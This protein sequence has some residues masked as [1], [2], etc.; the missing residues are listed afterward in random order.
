MSNSMNNRQRIG[1]N[2]RVINLFMPP[3]AAA[4]LIVAAF[5]LLFPA[6]DAAAQSAAIQGIIS[7]RSDGQPLDGA[8]IVLQEVGDPDSFR[9]TVTDRNGFYQMSG[10]TPGRHSVRISYIGYTAYEDTLSLEAD[11]R[12]T[13]TVSLA[14][15]DEELG[16]VVVSSQRH[17]A[18][19]R[20][21][22]HQRVSSVDLARVPTPAGG[23][24]LASYLQAMPGV[25]A[26]GD[27]GGQ[28]FIRGGTPSQNMVLVDGSVIY[29]PFHIVG[30]FSAFPEELV[31]TADFYAG[32][33]G[34]RY[35]SRISSVLDVQMRDGDRYDTGGSG[36][37]SP[38]VAEIHAEGP[39]REGSSSWIASTRHSLLE[40]T[41][42]ALLG[43]RQPLHFESQYLRFSHTAG[44]NS[45]CSVMALRTYD[46]GRLDFESDDVF[47]WNN[48]VL[49]GRCLALPEGSPLFLETNMGV[50]HMSNAAGNMENPELFSSATRFN[51]DVNLTQNLGDVRL[52]YG[53]FALMKWFNYEMREL[54]HEP[55]EASDV[56]L[57]SGVHFEASIP[58]GDRV[59]IR[60]GAVL[61]IYV[62]TYSPSVEPRIRATWQP[63]GREEEELSASIG[64]Y[65]QALVGVSDMRDASS[66]FVAWM[67]API[68]GSQMEAIH[69]LLGWR[70]SLGGGFQL[71]LEGYHKRLRNLPVT[72]WSTIA[73]FSTDLAL[74]DGEVYGG[75]IRLEL[76]RGPFYGFAGYGYTWT[77]YE[78]A[79]DHFNT[80]FGEPVQK[81]H[82]PHD[83]RH[84]INA[85]AS[86]DVG[87][88]TTSA[89]WQLGSGLP[90]TRP[91]G[92]DEIIFF[93]EQLPNVRREYGTPRVILEKPYQGRLPVYHRLDVSVETSIDF[94][95]A[96]LMAQAGA[97]NTY[98]QNNLF[99]YDVYTHRRI[100]QMPFA[101]YLSIKLTI[102]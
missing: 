21:L 93:G 31:A 42:E 7:D 27:R 100:D 78:A 19:R 75:D 30:F 61:S 18:A 12:L 14:A 13:L 83:R 32:G 63:F 54:F 66:V 35:N 97:I 70:Q 16:E 96:R 68:G 82:P 2:Q 76:Q 95:G 69:S 5:F 58:L 11:Q 47:R 87:R 91:M 65:R 4:T 3:M 37:V 48:F 1:S 101:P 85:M 57:G 67:P 90:F 81:Y 50:S 43:E 33:F 29:Q 53:G 52:E 26:A 102:L 80:W 74:A 20:D 36:S 84:Q 22:G 49:G 38:F 72:V 25:V 6:A 10:I 46:R 41:S 88:F 94:P 98:N 89:R 73:R 17:G 92:F 79:Q 51:M 86:V 39:L 15:D 99:Y 64:I 59:R 24:D 23:G 77:Q 56:I 55:R 45:R 44:D 71:S 40:H 62:K 9:G 34:P 8:N 60:P 28:L